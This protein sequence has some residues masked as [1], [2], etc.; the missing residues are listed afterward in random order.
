MPQMPRSCLKERVF[1]AG[2]ASWS[3]G[4]R[5]ARVAYAML[6]HAPHQAPQTAPPAAPQTRT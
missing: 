4:L 3:A 5:V 2:G 6:W 1:A